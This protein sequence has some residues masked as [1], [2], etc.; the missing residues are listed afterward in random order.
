[1]VTEQSRDEL[2]ETSPPGCRIATAI[3]TSA[4]QK[5][6]AQTKA[7]K[8]S[9]RHL[10]AAALRILISYLPVSFVCSTTHCVTRFVDK[11]PY[12]DPSPEE[13]QSL[14]Q[15]LN[16]SQEKDYNS[17]VGR[18]I[19]IYWDGDDVRGTSELLQHFISIIEH[20]IYLYYRSFTQ[21]LSCL[22]T[23]TR[24]TW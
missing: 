11:M 10:Q 19:S 3:S 17:V 9:V 13:L 16:A 23:Q 20:G 14:K 22:K 1:M 6:T 24:G 2:S 7:F 4:T 5:I 15:P 12:R 21:Q 18:S 8:L